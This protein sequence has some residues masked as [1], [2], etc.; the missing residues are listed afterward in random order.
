MALIMG[1]HETP[2]EFGFFEVRAGHAQ[3]ERDDIN[4]LD[5]VLNTIWGQYVAL[6]KW[7]GYKLTSPSVSSSSANRTV[8]DD[9]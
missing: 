4:N 1:P 5:L 8:C 2:Y 6:D 9:Q 7:Y 3:Y